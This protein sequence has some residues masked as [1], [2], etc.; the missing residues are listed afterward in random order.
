MNKEIG[1][2]EYNFYLN[3]MISY[4]NNDFFKESIDS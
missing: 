2:R 3:K 4:I 1:K